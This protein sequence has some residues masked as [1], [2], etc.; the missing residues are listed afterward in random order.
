MSEEE[1][2][3]GI[4]F[5]IRFKIGKEEY[6]VTGEG[7]KRFTETVQEIQL[8]QEQARQKAEDKKMLKRVV[9]EE[10]D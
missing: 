5:D 9:E 10:A 2:K 6:H 4:G 7:K 3:D 8:V 1:P